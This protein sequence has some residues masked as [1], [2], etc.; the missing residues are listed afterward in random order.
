MA[1]PAKTS[2]QDFIVLLKVISYISP[3]QDTRETRSCLNKIKAAVSR[4]EGGY[5]L[6]V[7]YE[8][9][10]NTFSNGRIRLFGFH[11]TR[12]DSW[13]ANRG[14]NRHEDTYTFSKTIPLACEA[15][16]NGL[17][18]QR[19]PRC[20]FLKSLSAHFWTLRLILCFRAVRIP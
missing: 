3:S 16:L 15:P 9:N 10:A 4:N 11:S 1:F 5:F 7:L 2:N 12:N 20:A 6:P 18:F 8:L 19:V 13:V 14:L 17:A